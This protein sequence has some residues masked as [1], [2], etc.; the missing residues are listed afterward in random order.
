MAKNFLQ[1]CIITSI[2]ACCYREQLHQFLH[3]FEEL[4]KSKIYVENMVNSTILT[5]IKLYVRIELQSKVFHASLAPHFSLF[6]PELII[7]HKLADRENV[8]SLDILEYLEGH[9][10][11]KPDSSRVLIHVKDEIVTGTIEIFNKE[12]YF[13]EPSHRH[14][15]VPH[16]FHMIAY[17]LS[18]VKF[19][20]TKLKMAT[21]GH[22]CGHDLHQNDRK[23][24]DQDFEFMFP[25]R[26]VPNGFN[27]SRMKRSTDLNRHCSLALVADY[28]FYK[29]N[30]YNEASTINYM[31]N[32]MQQ[33]DDLFKRQSLDPGQSDDYKGFTFTIK[34]MEVIMDDSEE[35][36]ESYRYVHKKRDVRELLKSFSRGDWRPDYCLA[37]LFTNYDFD[38]GVLGLAYVANPLKS[39]VGGVCTKP[40]M[41]SD[42]DEIVRKFS[43]NTGLTTITNFKRVL[44]SSEIVF[45]AAHEFGHNFGSPH[46]PDNDNDCTIKD[47][48]YLMYP[49][50]VNG[51]TSNNYKFSPCSL[52]SINEVLKYKSDICFTNVLPSVCGNGVIEEGETCDPGM[53]DS[54]CC[55]SCKLASLA[56]CEPAND[57]CCGQKESDYRCKFHIGKPCYLSQLNSCHVERSCQQNV[58]T[59]KVQ[60]TLGENAEDGVS[61]YDGGKCRSG[62]CLDQCSFVGKFP[63]ICPEEEFLCKRC[64]KDTPEGE[65]QLFSPVDQNNTEISRY[66]NLPDGRYCGN[67]ACVDGVCIIG[68]Q[69][70]QEKL[71]EI[72]DHI[73]VD[74]V[75]RWFKDN[76]VFTVIVLSTIIWIPFSC[77]TSFLDKEYNEAS[78]RKTYSVCQS[79]YNHQ[80]SEYELRE[81]NTEDHSVN[82]RYENGCNNC[83]VV[84]VQDKGLQIN[85]IGVEPNT[86]LESSMDTRDPNE[87]ELN[88][89]GSVDA[90]EPSKVS[91]EIKQTRIEKVEHQDDDTDMINVEDMLKDSKVAK[92]NSSISAEH[93]KVELDLS[94]QANDDTNEVNRK[95]NERFHQT[96]E[97]NDIEMLEDKEIDFT[98]ER[99]VPSCCATML[100]EETRK[101]SK[102]TTL[103]IREMESQG[104][105]P[106]E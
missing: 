50:A 37:H 86:S 58:E 63:C 10:V 59:N 12:K 1:F 93:I 55:S 69:D 100:T 2:G 33:V 102:E 75:A 88:I 96:D 40:Y 105:E 70:V 4:S 73:D 84:S 90:D 11:D 30:E 103:Q 97:S 28:K 7:K 29:L 47:N 67:G 101:A 66:M 46:D 15:K 60:C 9:L 42:D 98:T 53:E 14:I 39:K 71:W 82:G 78:V 83:D 22:F 43:T 57:E 81:T 3:D 56:E 35:D 62:V 25:Q 36:S 94:G 41:E 45:V 27:Y 95:V 34:Y 13:I 5:G 24:S 51:K 23:F 54:P 17:K 38:G 74:M 61:C 16:D 21:E 52:R 77:F 79:E 76:I 49:A 6:H 26:S 106:E 87:L 65:C 20:F 19:N 99:S 68:A 32:I 92:I 72:Y 18:D 104:K 80:C 31:V 44:L 8:A 64:C 48:K 89:V 85:V 91:G